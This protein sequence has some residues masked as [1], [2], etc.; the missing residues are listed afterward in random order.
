MMSN[1]HGIFGYSDDNWILAPS[2]DSLE[3]MLRTCEEYAAAHNLRFSTDPNPEKCKT[4]LMAFLRKPRELPNLSL[5]GTPLPWVN[6][7]KHLGNMVSNIIDGGQ[8]DMRVK[9]ARYI[10]KNNTLCQ[11]L[12]FAHPQSKL[13]INTIYNSHFSGSQ[14]WKFGS[15]EMDKL[16]SMY[17]KSIKIMFDLPWATHRYYMEPLTGQEHV[18]KTLVKRYL[19]FIQKILGS[20]KSALVS[21]LNLVKN[22]T[23]TT[24]G[25]NLRWIMLEASK[26]NIEEVINQK[27]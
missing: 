10:D 18:R 7:I 24:T 16:E 2:L 4:K 17:N 23:R 13:K 6:K 14:L 27:V 1:Y 3:D 9:I 19:S 11:E 26:V 15:R 22:D 12:F 5:C 25:S 21:L 8:L 20:K